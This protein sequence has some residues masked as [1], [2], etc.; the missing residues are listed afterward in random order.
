MDP[1]R[2]VKYYNSQ[3][4][5]SAYF[6]GLPVQYGQT[7]R[8]FGSLFSR[9][10]RFITP[11]IKTG[12]SIA[13]PHIK[14]AAKNIAGELASHAIRRMTSTGSPNAEPGKQEGK[15]FGM[16]KRRLFPPGARPYKKRKRSKRRSVTKRARANGRGRRGH[17][18]RKARPANRFIF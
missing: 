11:L 4:G 6:T 3:V 17:G 13:R 12:V 16:M 2:Y 7:G 5:G 10:F 18:R 15:G 14:S 8:G 1:Y 9:L